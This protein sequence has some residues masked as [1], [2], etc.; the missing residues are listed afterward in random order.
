MAVGECTRLACYLA[1]KEQLISLPMVTVAGLVDGVNPCAI[2]MMVMLLGYLLVFA[3]KPERVIKTGLLYVGTVFATYLV[4]GLGLLAIR[5]AVHLATLPVE[6]DASFGKALP[7]LERGRYLSP[8]D[9][10]AARHVLRAAAWT[11]VAA[12]LAT[13]LDIARWLR[14]LRF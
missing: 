6:F 9:M 13:L 12:A 5:I 3:K 2:G 8:A 14:V 7:A 10:P 1:G 4:V 11:Y